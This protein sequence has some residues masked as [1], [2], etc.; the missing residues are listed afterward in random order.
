MFLRSAPLQSRLGAM[1]LSIGVAS[2]ALA[3]AWPLAA[4]AGWG[5]IIDIGIVDVIEK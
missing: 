2:L 1:T 4:P 5:Q 3:C